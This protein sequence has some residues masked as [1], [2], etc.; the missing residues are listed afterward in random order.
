M[1][2]SALLHPPCASVSQTSQELPSFLQHMFCVQ[3]TYFLTLI[4]FCILTT[5]AANCH[6]C[7][8]ASLHKHMQNCPSPSP[9]KDPTGSPVLN[10][11]KLQTSQSRALAAIAWIL[12]VFV[13]SW[14][15]QLSRSTWSRGREWG[16]NKE[17]TIRQHY[18]MT[19]A[20][21]EAEVGLFF[22]SQLLYHSRYLQRIGSVLRS[23]TKWSNK[24]KNKEITPGSNQTKLSTKSPS[25]W[26]WALPGLPR[27]KGSPHFLA[28]F[29]LILALAQMWIFLS[30]PTS[31]KPVTSTCQIS[32][33]STKNSLQAFIIMAVCILRRLRD[34]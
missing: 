17:K 19:P 34:L 24:A 13:D 28:V 14:P 27:Q 11:D 1:G 23:K 30:E 6:S 31:L 4:A 25:L 3:A 29:T 8:P 20:S 15:S 5:T 22:P 21:A 10:Q 18:N 2:Q 9:S 33:S 16:L 32:I 26:I 12:P 7:A